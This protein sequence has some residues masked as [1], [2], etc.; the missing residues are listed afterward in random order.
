MTEISELT[1]WSWHGYQKFGNA[2]PSDCPDSCYTWISIVPS[3]DKKDI[4]RIDGAFVYGTNDGDQV[5]M[6]LKLQTGDP[7]TTLYMP[8]DDDSVEDGRRLTGN[9]RMNEAPSLVS[10]LKPM[11]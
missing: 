9:R 7:F 10:S 8:V 3:D 2:T 5:H 11:S 4:S 6:S 1:G